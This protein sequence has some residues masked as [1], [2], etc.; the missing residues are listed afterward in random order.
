LNLGPTDYEAL[1]FLSGV[2]TWAIQDGAYVGVNPMQG[3]KAYGWKKDADAP[4]LAHLPEN[5][6]I[7]KQPRVHA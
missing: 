3:Q 6:Q 2:F 5:E 1:A 4:S 7:R